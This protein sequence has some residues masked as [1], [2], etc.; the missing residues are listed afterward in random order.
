MHVPTVSVVIPCFNQ[1]HFLGE[2]IESVCRQ[3][4]PA[5]ELFVVDDGSTDTTPIVAR[6]HP[7]VRYLYQPNLGLARARNRGA[8]AST[9]E[10]VVFLDANDRL[11]P[12]ALHVGTRELRS[13]TGVALTYGRCQRI[14]ERGEPLPTTPPAALGH[15]VY[16]SL[17]TENP[18]WTPAVAMFRRE[19]CGPALRFDPSIDASADYELYLRLARAHPVHEHGE[20][21]AEYRRHRGSMSHDAALM[22]RTTLQVMRRQRP[23]LDTPRRERAYRDGLRAWRTLH[24]EQ[25]VEQLRSEWQARRAVRRVART[26]AWLAR[27]YPGGLARHALR[28]LHRAANEDRRAARRARVRDASNS[29]WRA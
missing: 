23:Y 19:A 8:R 1:G 3:S 15:D 13:R 16:A 12:D 5:T 29:A 14:D 10:F 20:V 17:L 6:R 7:A 11:R 21:V 26:V 2:A 27:Y 24:G 18:I 22:L 9:C 28:K 4:L 25:I